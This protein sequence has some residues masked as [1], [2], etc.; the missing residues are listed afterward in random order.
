M[1]TTA[2]A[3]PGLRQHTYDVVV[4]GSGAAAF[5]TAIGAADRGLGV[6]MLESTDKWGGST[7]M[8][9]GGLWMPDNPLMRRDGAGDS[10]E[11][12]LTYLETTVGDEGRATSP[13]RKEA[14]VDGVGDFVDL[15][16]RYGVQWARAKDYPDY[17]PELP[18]GKIG[19]GIEARPF[20]LD[21][22]GDAA[23]TLRLLLPLPLMTDDVWEIGRAW[24][25]VGGMTRGV[26]VAGRIL[27]GLVRGKKLAGIGAGLAASLYEVAVQQLGVELWLDSPVVDLE[28]E[29][30]RVV[31]VVARRDGAQ[32]RIGARR[33]VML[34]A[35]GFDHNEDWRQKHH[36][37]EGDPSGAPGNLGQ[38]HEIAAR[39][40]AALELMDDAWWG[41]SVSP[42]GDHDPGFIVGERA[43]PYTIMVDSQGRRFANE[44]ESYVDLGHHMLE[45]DK[46]GAYWII[47]EARHARRYLRNYALDPRA[48]KKLEEAGLLVKARTLAELA[49]K[50]GFDPQAFREQIQR[51]NGFARSGVDGDFGKGNSAYDRYYGDPTVRPNP[52]LGPIEKG[53]FSAYRVVIGDLGTKGG[54]LTDQH[55]RALREDG[56]VIEGLYA[57]G[58]VSASVMGRTY[59]GPGST[60]APASVFGLRGGRHMAVAAEDLVASA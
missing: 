16:E 48:N 21:R 7:A 38:V 33:G 19:R 59:P 5:A 4:V 50:A 54:V 34:A 53:P 12:A 26:R 37:I 40:G 55:A 57:A 9:G 49:D 18:G 44:A 27:G 42:V 14:F 3:D 8:S 39:H 31:G 15:T 51:F 17:Y 36:G 24:S 30:G 11:E 23:K 46:D 22:I 43:L 20:D 10:R 52:C 13:E 35:G 28:V 2:P 1:D 45:H 58:N 29:D 41:A 25:T 56:S 60:I 47:S 6:L 32:V